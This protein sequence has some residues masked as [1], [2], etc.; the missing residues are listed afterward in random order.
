M[1]SK[2]LIII[3]SSPGYEADFVLKLCVE[4]NPASDYIGIDTQSVN[5]PT[6]STFDEHELPGARHFTIPLVL[7]IFFG[8]SASSVQV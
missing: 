7:L 6:L 4:C 1:L 5:T 8:I 2:L 3:G